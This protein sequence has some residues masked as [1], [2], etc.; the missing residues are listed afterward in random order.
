MLRFIENSNSVLFCVTEYVCI[1]C[2]IEAILPLSTGLVFYGIVSLLT[3][4]FLYCLHF[5]IISR[6]DDVVLN[7]KASTLKTYL[8]LM[9]NLK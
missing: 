1:I 6:V 9:W 3:L 7:F 4:K 5:T 8:V 2:H